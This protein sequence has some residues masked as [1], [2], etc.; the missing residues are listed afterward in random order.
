MGNTVRYDDYSEVFKSYTKVDWADLDS[1]VLL[2]VCSQGFGNVKQCTRAGILVF[3]VGVQVSACI[4][5]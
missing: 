5:V 3:L 4:C 2:P 1:V